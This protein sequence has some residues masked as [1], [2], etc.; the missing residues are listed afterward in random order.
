MVRSWCVYSVCIV[1]AW[2]C[3]CRERGRIHWPHGPARPGLGTLHALE[4]LRAARLVL[5]VAAVECTDRLYQLG[6]AAATPRV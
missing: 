2:R 3:T 5:H 6:G 1:C 4:S